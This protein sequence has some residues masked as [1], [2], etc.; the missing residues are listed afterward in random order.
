[1]II[2]LIST[3]NIFKKQVGRAVF[4]GTKVVSGGLVACEDEFVVDNYSDPKVVY[5]LGNGAGDFERNMG[6]EMLS[7]FKNLESIINKKT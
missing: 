6:Q 1:M 4:H 3:H 5:G 7:K 2:S